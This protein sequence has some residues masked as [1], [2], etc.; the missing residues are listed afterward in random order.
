MTQSLELQM[1]AHLDCHFYSF[2]HDN[3]GTYVTDRRVPKNFTPAYS[4]DNPSLAGSKRG[5]Y[6]RKKMMAE[7]SAEIWT[8][9]RIK[10]LKKLRDAGLGSKKIHALTGISRGEIEGQLKRMGLADKNGVPFQ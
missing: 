8:P 2:R 6:S 9:K 4:F 3:K 10:K 1:K 7:R 5:A